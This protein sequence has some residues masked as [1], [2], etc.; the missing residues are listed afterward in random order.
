ME[1]LTCVERIGGF[2][3]RLRGV[4]DYMRW[5]LLAI[6]GVEFGYVDEPLALY[7]WRGD[8]FSHTRS[9]RQAFVT[10]FDLLL[11]EK[12][13]RSR[14]GTEAADLVRKQLY[15]ARRDLAYLD[16]TE[17]RLDDAR[18][19]LLSLI[20]EWPLR[21]ELYVDVLK[22]ALPRRLS[23]AISKAVTIRRIVPE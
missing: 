3:P 20:R 1:R 17:G 23:T 14:C 21:T 10:M 15:T 12:A 22:F 19:Q 7:R 5:I 9:Y 16:R 2:D 6:E 4:D 18:R 11:G 13:L 8:Q